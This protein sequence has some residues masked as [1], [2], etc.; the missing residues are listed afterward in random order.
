MR[1]K[2]GAQKITLKA[3][4]DEIK[5]LRSDVIKM[6]MERE[7]Y[8]TAIQTDLITMKKELKNDIHG[9]QK[10]L[11]ILNTDFKKFR[12]ETAAFQRGFSAKS[13]RQD[14]INFKPFGLLEAKEV[15]TPQQS[16]DL[17]AL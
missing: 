13:G 6:Q 11:D 5:G 7:E 16:G 10:Q 8:F 12:T 14:A 2:G 4:L 9:I 1:K 3:I 15:L 17:F